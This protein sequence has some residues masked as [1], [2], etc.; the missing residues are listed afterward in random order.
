MRE[1]QRHIVG[2]DGA[3]VAVNGAR[4]VEGVGPRAGGVQRADG[5]LAHV[6]GLAHADHRDPPAAVE[7]RVRDRDEPV[8]EPTRDHIE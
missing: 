2:V 5:F 6:R 3:E 4:G 7:Y 8:V 1:E